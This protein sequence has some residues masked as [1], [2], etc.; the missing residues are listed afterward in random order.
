MRPRH[1]ET[2]VVICYARDVASGHQVIG[3]TDRVIIVRAHV[4]ISIL[5]WYGS[6]GGSIQFLY[7][8]CRIALSSNLARPRHAQSCK[9]AISSLSENTFYQGYNASLFEDL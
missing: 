7:D 1:S 8:Y 9:E 2:L 6:V 3:T 4:A 5:R